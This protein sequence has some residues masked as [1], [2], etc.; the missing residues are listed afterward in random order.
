[1]VLKF[2]KEKTNSVGRNG[3][4]QTIGI[5]FYKAPLLKVIML[6]PINTK[7]VPANCT[8]SIPIEDIPAFI[9]TL[10]ILNRS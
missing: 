10:E 6:S 3:D 8:I 9:K 5:E 4:I 1:M 7:D 2:K